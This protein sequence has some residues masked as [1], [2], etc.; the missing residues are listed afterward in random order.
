[1]KMMINKE[2]NKPNHFGG[3]KRSRRKHDDDLEEEKILSSID[4]DDKVFCLN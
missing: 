3:G 2:K 1:M 4:K